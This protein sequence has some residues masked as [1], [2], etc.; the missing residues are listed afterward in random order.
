MIGQ[1]ATAIA[2]NQGYP[3]VIYGVTGNT[4]IDQV[5]SFLLNGA[6]KVFAKPLNFELLRTQ[7]EKQH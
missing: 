4:E 7:I 5:Q 2:R 6:D 3:G 1:E